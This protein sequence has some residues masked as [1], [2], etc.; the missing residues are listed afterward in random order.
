MNKT[1]SF[2]LLAAAGMALAL[3][4]CGGGGDGDGGSG[5]G[6]VVGQNG[7]VDVGSASM[8][9]GQTCGIG[10]FP[11]ALLAEINKARAQARSCGGQ[12]MPAVPAIAYWNTKLQEAAVKHS[13]DMASKNFF[14]HTGS[15]GSSAP[16][17]VAQFGYEGG[18]A[19]N[20]AMV[21]ISGNIPN[22]VVQN[23]LSSGS[24]CSAIMD[25]SK[26]EIGAACIKGSSQG[27]I[28]LLLGN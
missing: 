13:A 16:D 21:N 19:E 26:S 28:T 6:P 4:A 8:S 27:Y 20:L 9:G 12:N 3:V 18:V 22:R 10:N 25:P 5:S 24:H 23:W 14:S 1:T 2:K 17:R 11:Q 7:T 15:D